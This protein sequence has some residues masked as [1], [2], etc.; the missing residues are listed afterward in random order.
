MLLTALASFWHMQYWLQNESVW[1]A[2]DFKTVSFWWNGTELVSF[3]SELALT[4]CCCWCSQSQWFSF[5]LWN[6]SFPCCL[7]GKTKTYDALIVFIHNSCT[8]SCLNIRHVESAFLIKYKTQTNM[9]FFK[10]FSFSQGMDSAASR[11]NL[12]IFRLIYFVEILIYFN[13][14]IQMPYEERQYCFYGEEE[15]INA[16]ALFEVVWV[17]S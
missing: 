11:R 4:D 14:M 15:H 16:Q 1:S 6:L 13:K 7:Q 12:E 3:P 2:G 5:L 17:F 8:L 9:I 10:L